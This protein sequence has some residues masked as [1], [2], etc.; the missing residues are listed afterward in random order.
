MRKF[1][2]FAYS[3]A[4]S[5]AVF[6]ATATIVWAHSDDPG[7]NPPGFFE[8][9][10]YGLPESRVTIRAEG[11]KRIVESNAIPNHETGPFPNP[12]NPNS[13]RPRSIH[14]EMPL[15]PKEASSLTDAGHMIFG[16]AINGVSFDPATAEFWHRDFRSIWNEEAIYKGR[17]QLG[18]DWSNAHVQP[19]GAYH[20]HGIPIGLIRQL[21]AENS[22]V[23]VGWA[24]DGF[25]IYGPLA[26]QEASN[27]RSPLVKM[28]SSYRLKSDSRPGGEN[29][30][31]G[32]YDGK[33]TPDYEYV[34]GSGDLDE[35]NG[36]H[37]VTAEFPGGTY[38]YVTTT[39]FPC[40]GRKYRGAPDA[41]FRHGGPGGPGGPPGGPGRFGPPPGFPP[42]PRQFPPSVE[43]VKRIGTSTIA[44][45]T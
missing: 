43:N 25:P 36:R 31:G 30:P 7:E 10:A 41:S 40:V 21:H 20:Y 12:G 38:Y 22:M 29:G 32:P 3:L 42:P 34:A 28:K 33:Y 17:G 24:A 35:C 9:I 2:T 6:A 26:Y 45:T 23:L 15:H 13:I 4:M 18:M 1:P 14:Y 5:A 27:A 39:E 11:E 8:P 19:S 16:V 37:G 44:G